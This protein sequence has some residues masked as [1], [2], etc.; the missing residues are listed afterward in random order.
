MIS[1]RRATLDDIEAMFAADTAVWRAGFQ[2]TFSGAVFEVGS[3][4]AARRT[5]CTESV[6]LDGTDT[7]VG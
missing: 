7:F 3:F 2:Y 1:A 6:F 5:E 4:D